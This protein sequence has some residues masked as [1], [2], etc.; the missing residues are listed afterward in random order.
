MKRALSIAFAA[1]LMV[2]T[3][4]AFAQATGGGTGG[5]TGSDADTEAT[6]EMLCPDSGAITQGKF[7]SDLCWSCMMP[8]RIAGMGGGGRKFPSDMADPICVCPSKSLYGYPTPGVTQGMWKPSHFMESV[9]KPGCMPA[10]GEQ[11]DL[12]DVFDVGHGGN[13]ERPIDAGFKNVHQYSFPVGAILDMVDSYVCSEDNYDMDLLALSELDPTWAN[14]ELS[15][16]LNPDTVLFA[17]EI[18]TVA[19]MADAVASSA[20][21]PIKALFWCAGSW[22]GM[23]PQMG[24]GN[25]RSAV[26]DASL[27]AARM[28]SLEH[29]RWLMKRTYGNDSVCTDSFNMLYQKHQYR[30]QILYPIPQKQGN[31]WTGSST[32]LSREFRHIAFVGE[33]WVQVLW[34]YEECCVHLY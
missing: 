10:I 4:M 16:T 22:G 5:G 31:D 20:Y 13:G 33:D 32:M 19:C 30:W 7:A 1:A 24:Y 8:I 17:N 2:A 9:S 12:G 27:A 21:R 14:A 26:Q 6:K 3:P 29:K 11:T 34:R 25:A 28:V 18:A 15:M 23:Y